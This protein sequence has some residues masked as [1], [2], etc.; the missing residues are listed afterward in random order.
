MPAKLDALPP[1]ASFAAIMDGEREFGRSEMFK[2]L[3]ATT[4]P[5][6]QATAPIAV[7]QVLSL[8]P[9]YDAAKAAATQSPDE[10]DKALDAAVAKMPGNM[11]AKIMVPDV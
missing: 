6:E 4:D 7:Q 1:R 3:S 5:V 2:R 11:F 10:F 8:D 9:L